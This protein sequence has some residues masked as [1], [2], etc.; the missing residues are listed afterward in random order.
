[1]NGFKKIIKSNESIYGEFKKQCVDMQATLQNL[2]NIIPSSDNVNQLSYANI[3][4][5]GGSIQKNTDKVITESKIRSCKEMNIIISGLEPDLIEEGTSS[6]SKVYDLIHSIDDKAE[7]V[8]SVKLFS[9]KENKFTKKL[10]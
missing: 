1:M 5:N 10:W 8:N 4:K 7:I 2:Q 6:Q 3:V 9:K